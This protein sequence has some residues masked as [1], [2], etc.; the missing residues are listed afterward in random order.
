MSDFK[1]SFRRKQTMLL[2]EDSAIVNKER[3]AY[4]NPEG[5]TQNAEIK[6]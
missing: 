6:I 5:V 1:K 2:S 4:F 3:K